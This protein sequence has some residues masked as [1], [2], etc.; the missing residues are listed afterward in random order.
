MGPSELLEAVEHAGHGAPS[1]AIVRVFLNGVDPAAYRQLTQGD[2]QE[3]VPGALHV[4]VDPDF[5]AD[6][7]SVQGGIQIGTL[8]AEWSAFVDQ[9]D[10]AGMERDRVRDLGAHYLETARGEA[11]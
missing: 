10:L 5:G 1:G 6:A 11:V 8:E 9:Q 7:L 4:Q 3:T 2:F